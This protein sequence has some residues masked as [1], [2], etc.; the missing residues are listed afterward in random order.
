MRRYQ[1]V[2]KN[3]NAYKRGFRYIDYG[4]NWRKPIRFLKTKP[5]NYATAKTTCR[6]YP[7][8]RRN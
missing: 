7:K 3:S 8:K 2:I 1:K 6:P 5:K 4:I